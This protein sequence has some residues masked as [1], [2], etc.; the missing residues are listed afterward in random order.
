MV[1]REGPH[2]SAAQGCQGE[3]LVAR[4][5]VVSADCHRLGEDGGAECGFRR[6]L[7]TAGAHAARV[8]ADPEVD[9]FPAFER[10]HAAVGPGEGHVLFVRCVVVLVGL[11]C[12]RHAGV[13]LGI[14]RAGKSA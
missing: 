5:T 11:L 12:R 4:E 1:E 14:E 10:L 6:C 2:R 8:I 9:Q 13:R 3:F 7:R